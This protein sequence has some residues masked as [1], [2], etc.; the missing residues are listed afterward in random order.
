MIM[1]HAV[2]ITTPTAT[3]GNGSVLMLEL[4]GERLAYVVTMDASVSHVYFYCIIGIL[5]YLFT[6]PLRP[7]WDKATTMFRH[8]VLSLGLA[9]A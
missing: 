8:K 4:E 9:E 2:C 6:Y 7:Q 1:I 3:A 5:T